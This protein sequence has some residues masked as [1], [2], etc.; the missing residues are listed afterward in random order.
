M[1]RRRPTADSMI[2]EGQ[3]TPP[4]RNSCIGQTGRAPRA[5]VSEKTAASAT[6]ACGPGG[7]GISR[8]SRATPFSLLIGSPGTLGKEPGRGEPG[9]RPPGGPERPADSGLRPHGQPGA[10]S[11]ATAEAGGAAGSGGRETGMPEVRSQQAGDWLPPGEHMHPGVL[12][13]RGPGASIKRLP[14]Y[15]VARR[16]PGQTTLSDFSKWWK[17]LSPALPKMYRGGIWAF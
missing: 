1:G 4:L 7:V 6:P 8:S 5:P 13:H 16:C 12:E 10:G 14:L 9:A 17:K 2:R 3:A 15:T 11:V